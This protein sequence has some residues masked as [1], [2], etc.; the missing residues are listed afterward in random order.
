MFFKDRK[1]YV[2]N[3]SLILVLLSGMFGTV[4]TRQVWAA[5]QVQVSS[6]S[7]QPEM[8]DLDTGWVWT[9]GP[10]RPEIAQQAELALKK[11][12]IE[13]TVAAHDF[14]EMDACGNFEPFSTDFVVTLKNDPNRRQSPNAQSE[15]AESIRAALLPFGKP[16]LGNIRIDSG[17]GGARSYT[18]TWDEQALTTNIAPLPGSSLNAEAPLNKKVLL[19]VFDPTMSNGQDLNTYMGWPAYPTLVQG[20]IDSFQSASHG[21]LQYTVADTQVVS[22]EWPV[23]VDGFRYTEATYLAVMQNGVPGH[24][25]DEVDYN[26]ILDNPQFDICGKLNRGE[27]D[28]LWMY[29]APYFG[30]YESR[31]VGPGAYSYNSPP[32]TSTHNCNKLLPIMGLSYERG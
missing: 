13:S 27:I 19:L 22:A 29:G 25:P 2:L 1:W 8:C 18:S 16:Q 9:N 21:Q 5:P 30:F 4:P 32:L 12:G 11:N 26:V 28:E 10:V 15:M 14:G 3:Y 17:S 31:L 7:T 23:K 24:T 20:I 6:S